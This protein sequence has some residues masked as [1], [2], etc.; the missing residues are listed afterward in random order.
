MT[1]P[2]SPIPMVTG[3][4]WLDAAPPIHGILQPWGSVGLN[5]LRVRDHVPRAGL[6]H[7]VGDL[8]DLEFYDGL[9][10]RQLS[11]PRLH[12]AGLNDTSRFFNTFQRFEREIPREQRFPELTTGKLGMVG[13]RQGQFDVVYLIPGGLVFIC[14][15]RG[16]RSE[17]GFRDPEGIHLR[18]IEQSKIRIDILQI[19]VTKSKLRFCH[20]RNNFSPSCWLWR[21]RLPGLRFVVGQGKQV[22]MFHPSELARAILREKGLSRLEN[23]LQG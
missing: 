14:G 11:Q 15:L 19:R 18:S 22:E 6:L 21:F 20:C 7:Q 17:F 2:V 10:L 16:I 12:R 13:Y 3:L 1:L 23:P 4:L 9:D 8:I 5:S